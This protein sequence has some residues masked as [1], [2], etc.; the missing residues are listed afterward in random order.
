MKTYA[1]IITGI[2][3]LSMGAMAEASMRCQKGI[4]DEGDTTADVLKKCGQPA[5]RQVIEPIVGSNGQVPY[6][7]LPVER[8]VYGPSAGML[9]YLRF[10]DGK[11]VEI[12]SNRE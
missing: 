3:L 11:L 12:R 9:Y 7:S 6:K 8:W 10:L 2:T 5:D 1:V 4:I